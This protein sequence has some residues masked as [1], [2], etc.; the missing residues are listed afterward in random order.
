MNDV[1]WNHQRRPLLRREPTEITK[2]YHWFPIQPLNEQQILAGWWF[3]TCFIFPYIGNSII[4]IDELI[5]FR[6]V[7]TYHQPAGVSC[8]TIWSLMFH[9]NNCDLAPLSVSHR[10][11]DSGPTSKFRAHA[12]WHTAKLEQPSS[13]STFW[14]ENIIF[15]FL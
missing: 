13:K 8:S 1:W 4:P 2:N 15:L 14:D 12:T 11:R 9:P 3:G 5:F 6:G 7:E 10:S